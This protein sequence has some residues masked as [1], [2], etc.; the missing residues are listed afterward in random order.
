MGL[1]CRSVHSATMG[2]GCALLL[3]P[4]LRLATELFWVYRRRAMLQLVR[5]PKRPQV[6]EQGGR[7]AF[8]GR[9]PTAGH[10]V[11]LPVA[12]APRRRR[13]PPVSIRDPRQAE[14]QH[15]VP[16]ANAESEAGR[17]V[18]L[19]FQRVTTMLVAAVLVLRAAQGSAEHVRNPHLAKALL[20]EQRCPAQKSADGSVAA[21]A[22][23]H[24]APV[25][26]VPGQVGMS[27]V[28]DPLPILM[29]KPL[30]RLCWS[31]APFPSASTASTLA[32]G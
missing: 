5:A 18:G 26:K 12:R 3:D 7:L 27:P 9:R 22:G 25:S 21:Y 14:R 24:R 16:G 2:C 15:P 29:G 31:Y 6:G 20:T 32:P 30:C 13:R 8:I 1:G 19:R 4:L 10:P 17:T 28:I 23:L 11:G